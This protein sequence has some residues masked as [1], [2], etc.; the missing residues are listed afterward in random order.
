MTDFHL[1][2]FRT[3]R[4]TLRHFREDDFA[5]MRELDSNPEVVKYLGHGKVRT[6][7]ETT[8]NMNKIFADYEVF[9]IGLY[10][11][12]DLITGEKLG[13]SGLIPWNIEDELYW[14]VGYTFKPSAW[15]K[16]YAT[17]AATYLASW[18]QES[19]SEDFLVSLIHPQNLDSIN[20]ACKIGMNYWKEITI[21]DNPVS[22]YRTL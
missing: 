3:K 5:F 21:K 12:E 2:T 18:G 10:V 11:V 19:L 15:G 7:E 1:P 13:R 4:L 8:R 16:G 9:G 17:E 22:V 20:V 14:E 6:E